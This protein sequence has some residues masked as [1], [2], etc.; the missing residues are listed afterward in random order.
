MQNVLIRKTFEH[1]NSNKRI[2][3]K[4]RQERKLKSQAQEIRE[5][6]NN[7][8]TIYEQKDHRD[9]ATLSLFLYCQANQANQIQI[10]AKSS[11]QTFFVCSDELPTDFFCL[12]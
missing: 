4:L 11:Q 12:F 7:C 9:F 2:H 5:K 1:K 10:K 8:L 3:I 6:I